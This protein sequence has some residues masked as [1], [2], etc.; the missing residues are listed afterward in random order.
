MVSVTSSHFECGPNTRNNRYFAIYA[1]FL[2]SE[3]SV[4]GGKREK[5]I[6]E[7]SKP[8]IYNIRF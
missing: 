1:A 3:K 6:R 8:E 4:D 2:P 5:L 7:K